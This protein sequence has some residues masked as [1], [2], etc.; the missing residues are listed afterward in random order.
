MNERDVANGFSAIWSELFPMLSPPF[1]IGFNEAFVRPIY[2]R[3]GVVAPVEPIAVSQRP[4]VLAEFG[5]RL[6]LF[7]NQTV[8]R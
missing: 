2:G 3:A 8:V 7:A 1:I 5:F 4:D 6:A